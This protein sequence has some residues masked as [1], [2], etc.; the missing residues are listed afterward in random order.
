M[1]GEVWTNTCNATT[2]RLRG[3][4]LTWIMMFCRQ[5]WSQLIKAPQAVLTGKG[6]YLHDIPPASFSPS[7]N[8]AEFNQTKLLGRTSSQWNCAWHPQSCTTWG[9]SISFLTGH[10]SWMSCIQTLGLSCPSS[11]CWSPTQTACRDPAQ[12]SAPIPTWTGPP[13][14]EEAKKLAKLRAGLEPALECSLGRQYQSW[15]VFKQLYGEQQGPEETWGGP[16]PWEGTLQTLMCSGD[17]WLNFR[18]YPISTG[19]S[20]KPHQPGHCS[21]TASHYH[22]WVTFQCTNGANCYL[23]GKYSL[24]HTE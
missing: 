11:P 12:S 2:G 1:K 24:R 9:R 14:A 15:A 13:G 6:E 3:T 10:F 18:S 17:G 23:R 21:L 20:C 16:G 8:C 4:L 19:K 7:C 22:W 5:K